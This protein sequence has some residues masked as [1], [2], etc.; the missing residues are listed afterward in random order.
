MRSSLL[1]NSFYMSCPYQPLWFEH[2]NIAIVY[3]KDTI[4]C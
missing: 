4:S 3:S 2:C 1:A